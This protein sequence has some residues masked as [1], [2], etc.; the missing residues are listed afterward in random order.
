MRVSRYRHVEDLTS[1]YETCDSVSD[2]EIRHVFTDLL[3]YAGVVQSSEHA[4][5]WPVGNVLPV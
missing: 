1:S 3:D 4:R 5:R 2:F